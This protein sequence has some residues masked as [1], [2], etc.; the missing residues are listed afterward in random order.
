MDAEQRMG[1]AGEHL[2]ELRGGHRGVG[3]DGG[4]DVSEAVAVIVV[5]EAGERPGERV[6][7]GEIGR[8]RE[9]FVAGPEL[10]SI[11]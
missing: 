4:E 6:K 1:H 10:M 5:D 11:V 7:A 2:V 3:A 8:E 9:H